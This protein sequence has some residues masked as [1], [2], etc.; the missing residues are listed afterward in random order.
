MAVFLT[1]GPQGCVTSKPMVFSSPTEVEAA[2]GQC[3]FGMR[4]KNCDL[5]IRIAGRGYFV[6][7]VTLDSL[8]DAHAKDGMCRTIRKARVTGEIRGDSFVATRFELVPF[9]GR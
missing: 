3:L 7:G 6:D 5:A 4:G 8:G 9:T 2:C 1:L